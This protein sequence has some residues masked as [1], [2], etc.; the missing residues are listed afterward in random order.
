[1][2]NSTLE[3]L[4]ATVVNLSQ[5]DADVEIFEFEKGA[6]AT[7][8]EIERVEAELERPIPQAFKNILTTFAKEFALGLETS[9]EPQEFDGVCFEGGELGWSLDGLP[10][11]VAEFEEFRDDVYPDADNAY[12]RA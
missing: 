9:D 11:L 12:D 6:P 10:E 4:L 1:M 8:A 3:R 2:L 5:N 7:T